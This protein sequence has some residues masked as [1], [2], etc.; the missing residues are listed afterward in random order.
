MSYR[1]IGLE[2]WCTDKNEGG[3]LFRRERN[4][5][6][7][8]FR[9]YGLATLC[10]VGWL[11]VCYCVLE[12]FVGGTCSLPKSSRVDSELLA[13]G[14]AI[15]TYQI[16]AGRPP[17]TAQGLGCLV[18]EP[19]QGPKPRRWLQVMKK[20]PMD[21]WQTPYRYALLEPKE[22]EWHW[23]LRSAGRDC[24]FGSS[25]DQVAD[26]ESGGKM[27]SIP[28]EQEVGLDSRSSF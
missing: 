5:R 16:N 19:T 13:I 23:E 3:R 18:D 8:K 7:K 1:I 4:Q 9:F 22:Y 24:V 2:P 15:K 12:I 14:N 11:L 25:D 28:D 17:T 6:M 21:P 20:L 27:E 26:Y 10:G